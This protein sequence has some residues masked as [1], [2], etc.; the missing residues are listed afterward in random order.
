MNRSIKHTILYSHEPAIVWEYLTKSEL[1]EQW[2][3][4][5]NFEPKVGHEFQF[6]SK[7]IPSVDWDGVIYCKVLELIPLK[8]LSYS[9][10]GGPGDGSINM[11]SVVEFTLTK[12]TNGTEL[13]LVHSGRVENVDIYS[14]MDKGWKENIEKIGTLIQT[15]V[16]A[17]TN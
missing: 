11:D 4:K 17:A 8:K 14:M 7:P 9:W 6:R 3:M 13:S 1:I 10:K 15:T 5:N 12:K 16:K 2:L